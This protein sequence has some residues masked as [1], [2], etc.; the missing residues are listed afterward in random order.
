MFTLP[1]SYCSTIQDHKM[2][3]RQSHWL[4][5][6]IQL[7]VMKDLLPL[8]MQVLQALLNAPPFRT[9]VY[10][11]SKMAT[12]LCYCE[13]WVIEQELISKF[14][15]CILHNKLW[16]N[17][18]KFMVPFTSREKY[19]EQVIPPKLPMCSFAFPIGCVTR[20]TPLYYSSKSLLGQT[21]M[22]EPAQ[23]VALINNNAFCKAN[24]LTIPPSCTSINYKR[25]QMGSI[26]KKNFLRHTHTL[27]ALGFTCFVLSCSSN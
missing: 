15:R 3:S 13:H 14:V 22:V 5:D 7:L 27:L 4:S 10:N 16:I 8:Q 24:I 11:E 18:H 6:D 23:G 21:T 12:S 20:Y 19:L 9:T 25:N 2:L 1:L 26:F 17:T